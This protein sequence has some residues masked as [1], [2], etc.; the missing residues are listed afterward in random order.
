MP[1]PAALGAPTPAPSILDRSGVSVPSTPRYPTQ[2]HERAAAAIVEF[3]ADRDE[4]DAVLLVNSC[5]RGK[6]TPDSCL[7]IK[8]LVPE[9]ADPAALDEA[10]RRH[11]DAD[12]VFAALRQA[13]RFAVLH[14]DLEDGRFDPISP[15]EDEYPDPFEIAIGNFL[16]YSVPLWER[17]D[18]LAR[19]RRRWLPYY[20]E[21]LR[22]ERLTAAR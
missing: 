2:A 22:Q 14:L 6:A 4:T 3:F 16:V 8:V 11:H 17:G 1:V 13:G 18:R 5:A 12:P 19:L 15:P 21:A 7:D 9:E 10:W 20:D